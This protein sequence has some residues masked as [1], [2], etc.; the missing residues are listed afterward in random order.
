MWSVIS[1]TCEK[2]PLHITTKM[3][4][5]INAYM[6]DCN[7]LPQQSFVVRNGDLDLY[8]RC[9]LD[10]LHANSGGNHLQC[11]YYHIKK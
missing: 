3:P 5:H 2:E 1:D 7:R 8:N 9:V 6:Y 4:Y 11:D 10:M